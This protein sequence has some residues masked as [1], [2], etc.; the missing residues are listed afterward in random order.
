M[1][2]KNGFG[3]RLPDIRAHRGAYRLSENHRPILVALD[4][5]PDSERALPTALM[6]ARQWN[7]P[8]RLVHVR[9]PAEDMQTDVRL[10]DNE[11]SLS[12][13]S[14][15]GAY[16]DGLAERLRNSHPVSVQG[17]L[18]L[19][20]SVAGTLRSICGSDARALVMVRKRRSALA[21]FWWGSVTDGLVGRLA[22]PLLL[23]PDGPAARQRPTKQRR[24]GFA[25][26]LVHLDGS[27]AAQRVLGNAMALAGANAVCHLLRVLPLST[28][29]QPEHGGLGPANDQRNQAWRELHRARKT[30]EDRGIACTTQVIFDGQTKGRAILDQA[31]ATQAQVIVV[32]ACH[33]LLPR[34]LRSGVAEHVIRE[35]SVPVLLVPA[36]VPAD[37]LSDVRESFQ[38][39]VSHVGI[40]S[41]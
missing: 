7:A 22:T 39:E 20:H 11:G 3:S 8:L 31:R 1:W 29:S 16:L 35:A 4:G 26:I 24:S 10:V 21:R 38:P 32:G 27:N 41:N 33:H 30:L 13:Q 5:S 18:V 25:R 37:S 40:H 14:R 19:G 34:W 2:Q 12:V 15:S 6:L 23:I 28:L 9:D 36:D 17:E